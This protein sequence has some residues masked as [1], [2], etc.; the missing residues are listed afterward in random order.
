MNDLKIENPSIPTPLSALEKELS[1]VLGTPDA[2][3]DAV[4]D[5]EWQINCLEALAPEGSRLVC[6]DDLS[7]YRDTFVVHEGYWT[8]NGKAYYICSPR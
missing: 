3:V 1:N 8:I 7:E 4:E 5:L 6:I 2:D